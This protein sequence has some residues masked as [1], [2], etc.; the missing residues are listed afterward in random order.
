MGE[1]PVFYFDYSSPYAYLA[2][3][4]IG[5]LLPDAT[6][7]PIA[8]GALIRQI[9]KVPWSLGPG[10]AAGVREV[11]ER[12][13]A[14]GLPPV[15]WPDGWP[16]E[17]Y[18]LLPLRAALVADEAGRIV[19]FSLAVYRLVF[20]EGRT[21]TDPEPVLQAAAAAGVDPEALRAGVADPAIKSRLRAN[22]DE[23]IARG[24]T[25]VPTLAVGDELFWGDDRLE[26]AAAA[27]AP[28]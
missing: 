10:R 24:V 11:E 27:A 14:R 2:A 18:S 22:T 6:W 7:R 15:R 12:A 16:D 3:M 1:S 9:G 28:T 21:L 8:F 23:A 19:P 5:D 17:S 26:A 20:A 13:A 25:G 4:R